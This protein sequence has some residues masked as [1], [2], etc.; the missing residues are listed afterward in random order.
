MP[1]TNNCYSVELKLWHQLTEPNIKHK[2]CYLCEPERWQGRAEEAGHFLIRYPALIW[3]TSMG[4]QGQ[5]MEARNGPTRDKKHHTGASPNM[6]AD[7]YVKQTVA[8]GPTINTP[9][10]HPDL[11]ETRFTVNDGWSHQLKQQQG[12]KSHPANLY[13]WLQVLHHERPITAGCVAL[14]PACIYMLETLVKRHLEKKSVKNTI[15]IFF[16]QQFIAFLSIGIKTKVCVPFLFSI[17]TGQVRQPPL[18][19]LH[20]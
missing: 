9:P 1:K 5:R 20:C 17:P 18:P 15:Y 3:S 8:S 11:R 7:T 19:P 4:T 6:T 14:F 16:S 12:F 13:S 2:S 10:P